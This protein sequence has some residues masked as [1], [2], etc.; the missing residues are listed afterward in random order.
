MSAH[1]SRRKFLKQSGLVAGAGFVGSLLASCRAPAPTT[2]PPP[3]EKPKI[4]C[5]VPSQEGRKW[6][7]EYNDFQSRVEVTV[8][9]DP[10][11]GT[12]GALATQIAAGTS[13]DVVIVSDFLVG[14]LVSQRVLAPLDD[15]VPQAVREAFFPSLV[16]KDGRFGRYQGKLY[17]LPLSLDVSV[18]YYNKTLLQA[19]GG[20]PQAG[21]RSWDEYVLY[22]KAATQEDRVGFAMALSNTNNLASY[23]PWLWAQ[24][25][26]YADK[27]WTKSRLNEPAGVNAL[28]FLHDL[29]HVHKITNS[30]V[31]SAQEYALSERFANEKA[32]AC[33]A[34]GALFRY[35]RFRNPALLPALGTC[36]IPGPQAGQKS[37]LI[38]G[39]LL[40][41]TPQAKQKKECLDFIT[42]ATTHERGMTL[43]GELGLLAGTP[44]AFNLPIYKSN[45]AIWAASKEGLEIGNSVPNDPRIVEVGTLVLVAFWEAAQENGNPQQIADEAASKMNAI[46]GRS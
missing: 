39:L 41:M 4:V 20:D 11:G 35:I 6:A 26:D 12:Y 19:A 3:T 15:A 9:V 45:A 40:T 25:G 2:P 38:S 16:G 46:L 18:L 44:K 23:I 37:A 13:P 30:N 31:T 1:I 5:Y 8:Q 24:G 29:I 7:D 36:P 14:L 43:T 42:W 28:Q 33:H 22:G 21:V 32:L 17:G 34:G 27:G 10:Q